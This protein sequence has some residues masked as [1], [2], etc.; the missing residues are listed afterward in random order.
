[1]T[2]IAK[3]RA[4]IGLPLLGA[5]L[6]VGWSTFLTHVRRDAIA[7]AVWKATDSARVDS[8]DRLTARARNAQAQSLSIILAQ[9]D[10]IRLSQRK[11]AEMDTIIYTLNQTPF[12]EVH[13]LGDTVH[14]DDDPPNVAYVVHHKI[15][16]LLQAQDRGITFRDSVMRVAQ[17]VMHEQVKEVNAYHSAYDLLSVAAS[18]KDSALTIADARLTA[19]AHEPVQKPLLGPIRYSLLF[20]AGDFANAKLHFDSDRGGYKDAWT[21]I[22]KVAHGLAGALLTTTAIDLGVKPK[23]AALI[24]CGGAVGFEFSQGYASGKD[25]AYGCASAFAMAGLRSL[26]HR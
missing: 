2:A 23:W 21:G 18:Q 14:L 5:L 25:A 16:T 15:A 12:P 6:I 9:R 17:T 19:L 24:T 10:S 7:Q 3:V 20:A 22:D 11:V 4:L 26:I 1:M 13:V 8:I